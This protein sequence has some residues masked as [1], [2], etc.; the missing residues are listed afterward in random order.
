[1]VLPIGC[2]HTIRNALTS[3]CSGFLRVLTFREFHYDSIVCEKDLNSISVRL[4]GI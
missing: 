4:G 3:W 2:A 1:M